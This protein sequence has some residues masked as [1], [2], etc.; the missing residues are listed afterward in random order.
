MVCSFYRFKIEIVW[1]PIAS[2]VSS[3]LRASDVIFFSLAILLIVL[4]ISKE[5]SDS[6]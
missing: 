2:K 5:G 3:L 1:D 4:V 6:I